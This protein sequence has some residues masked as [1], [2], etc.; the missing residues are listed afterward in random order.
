MSFFLFIFTEND[1]LK[2]EVG[3]DLIHFFLGGRIH[4]LWSLETRAA[5]FD[6]RLSNL[7]LPSTL[8]NNV[9]IQSSSGF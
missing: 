8:V 7:S 2:K 6:C 5:A 3:L 1:H 9:Q 4:G